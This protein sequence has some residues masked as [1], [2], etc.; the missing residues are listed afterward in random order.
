MIWLGCRRGCD[1]IYGTL[2]VFARY[3]EEKAERIFISLMVKV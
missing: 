2:S 3:E 1:L